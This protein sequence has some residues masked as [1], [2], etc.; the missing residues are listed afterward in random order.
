M[1]TGGDVGITVLCVYVSDVTLVLFLMALPLS[2]I[3]VM[4]PNVTM[5]LTKKK[6]SEDT[7]FHPL[8]HFERACVYTY[9]HLL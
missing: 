5:L 3:K 4:S 9:H 7:T 6:K 1:L 2:V 8:P